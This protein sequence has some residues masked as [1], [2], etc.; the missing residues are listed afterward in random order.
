MTAEAAIALVLALVQA[1]MTLAKDVPELIQI[2]QNVKDSIEAAQA[3]GTDIT[4]AQIDKMRGDLD[5]A[6]AQLNAP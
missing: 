3:T 4:D 1:I 6:L 2:A 5:A